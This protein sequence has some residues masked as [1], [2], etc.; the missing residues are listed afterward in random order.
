M[1]FLRGRGENKGKN[2]AISGPAFLPMRLITTRAPTPVRQPALSSALCLP[3]CLSSASPKKEENPEN[4]A[5]SSI[6]A[7][8]QLHCSQ[9]RSQLRRQLRS[10]LQCQKL[11][12]LPL[13]TSLYRSLECSDRSDYGLAN[14]RVQS[15]PSLCFGRALP[16]PLS[17]SSPSLSLCHVEL[18]STSC[19]RLLNTVFERKGCH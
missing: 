17:L 8:E 2:K 18:L 5:Q 7:C 3:I 9:L 12:P 19:M 13:S 10:K 16:S 15:E 1:G 6:A 4:H 11:E 14:S